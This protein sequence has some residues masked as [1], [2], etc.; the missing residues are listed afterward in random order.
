[1][2]GK[3]APTKDQKGRRWCRNEE[4]HFSVVADMYSHVFNPNKQLKNLS[5]ERRIQNV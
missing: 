4:P 3:P 2:K 1:M 5:I